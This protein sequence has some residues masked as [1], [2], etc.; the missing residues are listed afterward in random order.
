MLC[1][2]IEIILIILIIYIEES[3]GIF[4]IY[5]ATIGSLFRFDCT[6]FKVSLFIKIVNFIGI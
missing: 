6:N 1:N 4:M 5:I 3:I 2:I